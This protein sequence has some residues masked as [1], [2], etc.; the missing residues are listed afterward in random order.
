VTAVRA[1]VAEPGVAA[2]SE[3]PCR[4]HQQ[5]RRDRGGVDEGSGGQVA[6]GDGAAEA[7]DPQRHH[8]PALVVGQVLLQ[9]VD[10]DV[11]SPN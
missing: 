7:H 5:H 11:M 9:I 4:A 2:E 6:D 10:N 3:G 8:P 1:V